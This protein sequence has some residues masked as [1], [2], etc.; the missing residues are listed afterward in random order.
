MVKAGHSPAVT[1]GWRRE[2]KA[3]VNVMLLAAPL[4]L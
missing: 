3:T 2:Q 4:S 1:E